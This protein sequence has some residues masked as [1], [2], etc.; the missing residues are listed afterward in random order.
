M[1]GGTQVTNKMRGGGRRGS[2]VTKKMGAGGLR[3]L[4][5]FYSFR[6][7]VGELGGWLLTNEVLLGEGGIKSW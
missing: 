5:F 6:A 1:G 7:G 4:N 2:Q 3:V